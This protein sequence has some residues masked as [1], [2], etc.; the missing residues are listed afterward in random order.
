M[1][2]GMKQPDEASLRP[3]VWIASCKD[4][5]LHAFMNEDSDEAKR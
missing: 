2:K 5:L 4:D 1:S 3:V